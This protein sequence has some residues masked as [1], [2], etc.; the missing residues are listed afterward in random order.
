MFM[1]TVVTAID[2][3]QVLDADEIAWVAGAGL[4][5]FDDVNWCGT[6]PRVIPIPEPDPF[7]CFSKLDMVALNPQPLPPKEFGRN[8]TF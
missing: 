7:P 5:A 6:V 2:D 4:L 1:Y 3:A 8:F